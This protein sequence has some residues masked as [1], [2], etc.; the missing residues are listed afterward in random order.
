MKSGKK[1]SN[2]GNNIITA[3]L[4]LITIGLICYIIFFNSTGEGRTDFYHDIVSLQQNVSYYLGKTRA[5]MFEAY[6]LNNIIIGMTDD[7]KEIKNVEDKAI[8]PVA[9]KDEVIDKNGTKY[10]KLN[11]NNVKELFKIELPKYNGISWYV[12]GNGEIK[13]KFSSDVP[14]WWNDNSEKLKLS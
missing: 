2:S 4:F 6:E 12:S 11:E 9:N 3:L 13:V 10:Y 1:S 5:E 14:K 8:T 7:G